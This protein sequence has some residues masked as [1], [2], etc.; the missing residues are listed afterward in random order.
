MI[1]EVSVEAGQREIMH[2]LYFYS[3]HTQAVD[4]LHRVTVTDE[5]AAIPPVLSQPPLPFFSTNG[6]VV[7]VQIF[8]HSFSPDL[9]LVLLPS[10][11]SSFF[12]PFSLP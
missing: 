6:S 11:S 12:L 7:D 10:V 1:I 2:N 4:T 5:V 8:H 3:Q 9:L